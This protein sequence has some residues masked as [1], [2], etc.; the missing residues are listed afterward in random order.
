MADHTTHSRDGKIAGAV[1]L[2]LTGYLVFNYLGSIRLAFLMGCIASA[3]I[4]V[5]SQLPDTDIQ[6]SVPYRYAVRIGS[7]AGAGEIVYLAVTNWATYLTT[8]R[9]VS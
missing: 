1:A 4:Y 3:G 8:I 9:R 6:S 2:P 5:G 7:L